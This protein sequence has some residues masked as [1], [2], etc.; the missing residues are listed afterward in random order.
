MVA[1]LVPGHVTWSG[2]RD[3]EGH[4]TWEV[5][6]YVKTDDHKDGPA[7]VMQT[8]GLPLPGS[9]WDFRT[10]ERG[11]YND[12]DLWAF[13]YPY[14]KVSILQEKTGDPTKFWQVQQKFSTKPLKRCADTQIEDPL[15]EPQKVSGG[16]SKFTKE[17]A[18]DRYGDLIR[19]S[20]HQP[21]TGQL[22]EFDDNR[23]TVHIEQNVLD[24]DLDLITQYVDHVNDDYLWGLG[25]RKVKLSNVSWERKLY[26][27]CYY[28]YTR[29][30]EFDINFQT[31]D[32]RAIDKGT[33]ALN[34]YFHPTSGR[35]TLRDIN[36][37]PPNYWNPTHFC[38][39]KDLQGEN[40]ECL[41]NGYG[42]PIQDANGPG[43]GTGTSPADVA[44]PWIYT[45][46]YYAE[47][48]FLLLGIPSSL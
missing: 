17:V 38:T 4:R 21:F 14:M 23:P 5:T 33:K 32:K 16:F 41:L 11:Q 31:F 27:T 10:V 26:G 30:F 18:F 2:E 44:G 9:P 37:Q 43:T 6:H 40:V 15:L 39:I 28:F 13:C 35:W 22:V 34:G 1:S 20:A 8:P 12:Y 7:I 42:I 46:E 36:H 3:D 25:P 45:I 48:N 47:A 24:L 29:S 19:N